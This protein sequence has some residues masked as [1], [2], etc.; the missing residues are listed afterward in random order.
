MKEFYKFFKYEE[1]KGY[2]WN[3]V[4]VDTILQ[5]V[6]VNDL[7]LNQGI[8]CSKSEFKTSRLIGKK[9]EQ[10]SK[11]YLDATI[12]ISMQWY[13]PRL[14]WDKDKNGMVQTRVSAE[15]FFFDFSPF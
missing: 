7:N 3:P 10:K 15:F 2:K 5:L 4:E 14:M 6:A 12:A 8:S 1:K 11:E 9:V 13:D